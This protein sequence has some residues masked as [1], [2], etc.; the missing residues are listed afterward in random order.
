MKST[1]SLAT[2]STSSPPTSSSTARRSRPLA[3]SS[4][5][6]NASAP[7]SAGAD[8]FPRLLDLRPRPQRRHYHRRLLAIS[9]ILLAVHRHQVALLP[10]D[11]QQDVDGRQ[12]REEQPR[13][14]HLRS[15]PE[16]QQPSH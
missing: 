14:R 4:I 5:W 6:R 15:R 13:R 8:R 10:P 9:P 1:S 3:T 11:R 2:A 16:R 7:P 12:D